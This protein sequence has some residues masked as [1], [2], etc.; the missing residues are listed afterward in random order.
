MP[1]TGFISLDDVLQTRVL[2]ADGSEFTF[3]WA[4]GP[5]SMCQQLT[6][7]SDDVDLL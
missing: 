4:R 6:N 2:S 1:R 5:R 3:S 7:R